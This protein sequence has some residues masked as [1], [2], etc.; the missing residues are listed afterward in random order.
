[1]GAYHDYN[2]IRFYNNSDMVTQV[3]SINNGSDTLGQN[4]VYVNNSLTAGVS[5]RAPIF[6]DSLSTSY[7]VDPGSTSNVNTFRSLALGTNTS[8]SQTNKNGLSLYGA[9]SGGLPTY[10]IIF[11]GVS[12]M[13]AFG[14]VNS[15][16]ATYFTMNGTAGRGWAFKSVGDS[17][18]VASITN[19]GWAQFA[20][21]VRTPIFYDSN[22]TGYYLNPASTSRLSKLDFGNS[23]Y[24]IHAGDWGMRNTTPYG[25]IQF[26]PANSG[27]AH[28]YTDRNKFYF[29]KE[30]FINGG[31]YL[32]QNDIRSKI[33][34]DIDNTLY[35]ADFANTSTSVKAA[36]QG[37]FGGDVIAFSDKKLKTNIKTLDGSKVL[38]MRGV[39]FDKINTGKKG[40]GVIAQELQEVAPELVNDNDGTLGVA[41]GN[42]T[43]YLIEAIKNQQKQIDE[44]T[45]I[46]D[47]LNK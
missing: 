40:S 18:P 14:G 45:N 3:M 34:Y 47:K 12:G 6:Y 38:K 19:T 11:S 15:D 33:F 37:V 28:I 24:Y 27:Y 16:W 29:N 4:N 1:M 9:Y 7:F 21:S 23:S 42:L 41:Y 8:G 46:I 43:G 35:Y 30:M 32:R 25:W 26:G 31:S 2:G 17:S 10:G 22:N 44:L 13:G 39:S 20:Q 36:G 5:L